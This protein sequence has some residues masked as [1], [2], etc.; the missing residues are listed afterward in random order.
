M[1]ADD[2]RHIAG[3]LPCLVAMKKVGQA[4]EIVGDED[5]DVSGRGG[6]GE[7]PVHA[8]L[9]GQWGEGSMKACFIAEKIVG[10]ELDAHE[11]ESKL[12]VLMLVGVED[13]GVVLMN[14]EVGDGG[15]ETFA[16]GAVNE[17]NGGTG[18]G[19]GLIRAFFRRGTAANCRKRT[20]NG[21]EE[22]RRL[23]PVCLLQSAMNGKY[24]HAD[25]PASGGLSS[26]F[27]ET[28][29]RQIDLLSITPCQNLLRTGSF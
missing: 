4:V 29:P 16:V 26:G 22:N 18:H 2:E 21:N 10:G 23:R 1:I 9:L 27:E 25:F 28:G 13:V 12:H 14:K 7:A 19:V 8:E 3:K 11:E 20:G 6:E 15:D 17:E 24:G 5:G